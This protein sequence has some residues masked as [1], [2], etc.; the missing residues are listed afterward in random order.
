MINQNRFLT[1]DS[2]MNI[3]DKTTSGFIAA[4]HHG[5]ILFFN[6]GAENILEIPIESAPQNNLLQYVLPDFETEYHNFYRAIFS[7]SHSAYSIITFQSSSGKMAPVIIEGMKIENDLCYLWM[8][9]VKGHSA[10]TNSRLAQLLFYKSV[11][12]NLNEGVALFD[13]NGMFIY[14]NDACEA[15]F[16]LT[17]EEIKKRRIHDLLDPRQAQLFEMKK[18]QLVNGEQSRFGI[19]LNSSTER[20]SFLKMTISP[21]YNTAKESTEILAIFSDITESR[22][23]EKKIESRLELERLLAHISYYF[24]HVSQKN[25]DQL[26]DSTLLKIGLYAKIDRSYLFQFTDDLFYCSNTHEWCNEK[27]EPQITNLQNIP[28]TFLPWW[29]KKLNSFEIIHIPSVKD[30]P[31]E[32]ASEKEIL[33]AQDIKSLIVLPVRGN[34]TLLGFIGFDSVKSY[35]VWEDSDIQALST[36]AVVFGNAITRIKYESELSQINKRLNQKVVERTRE[37]EKIYEFSQNVI[38]KINLVVIVTDEK[39]FIKTLNPYARKL[40][41]N[42]PDLPF[43]RLHLFDIL[44]YK[45]QNFTSEEAN[46]LKIPREEFNSFIESL[47]KGHGDL[48]E[49][50]FILV[51]RE[52]DVINV[53]LT[54]T[55]LENRK[56]KTD[57]FFAA[58]NITER[59][60]AEEMVK[61]RENENRAIVEAVPDMLF[62][63]GR[64]GQFLDYRNNRS[65]DPIIQSGSI[66]G[67]RIEELLPKEVADLT[68]SSLEQAFETQSLTHFDFSMTIDNKVRYFENRITTVSEEVAFSFVRDISHKKETEIAVRDTM[69]KLSVLIQSLKDGVLFEGKDKCISLINP[70]FIQLFNLE[71]YPEELIGNDFGRI[72]QK[73]KNLVIDCNSFINRM[74]E[75]IQMREPV[76]N[77]EIYFLDGRVFE[78]DFTP[79]IV[80]S[81]FIGQLWQYRDITER[82]LIEKNAIIER[83]LGFSLA[84][85]TTIEK[86]LEMAV[87]NIILIDCVD[88]VGIYFIN[89]QKGELEL[90]VS[91]GGSGEFMEKVGKIKRNDVPYRLFRKSRPQ[92]GHYSEMIGDIEAYLKAGVEY[93]GVIPIIHEKETIGS[94]NIGHKAKFP[95]KDTTKRSLEIIATL[96]GGAIERI[97]IENKLRRSQLNFNLLFNTLD[98]FVFILDL[99]GCIIN[100]NPIIEKRLGY[101]REELSGKSIFDLHPPLYHGPAKSIFQNKIEGIADIYS[102]PLLT[103]DQLEIPVET[104]LLVGKWDNNNV[105][106]AI[107]RDITERVKAERLIKSESR[108]QFALEGAGDGLWDMNLETTELFLSASWKT[109][110]GYSNEEIPNNYYEWASRVHPD[111]LELSMEELVDEIFGT[112]STYNHEHRIQCKDGNYKWILDRA[113]IVEWNALGRPQR[114]IG[115][116][117]DITQRKQFEEQLQKTVEREKEL[118]DLKSRFVS[119]ASHEF[120]TPLASILMLSEIVIKY[121]DRIKPAEVFEKLKLIKDHVMQLSD[122][123]NNVLQ[124]SKIKDGKIIYN[125]E[126]I[127]LNALC[128]NIM[129]GFYSVLESRNTI[130][131]HSDFNRLICLIDKQMI[132][133]AIT[134]LISNALKYTPNNP[135]IKVNLTLQNN[136]I[137]LTV[138]DNGIG[139]PEEDQKHMFTPFFRAGNTKTIQGNGLGLSIIRESIQMHHG[140]VSF[141]S[142]MNKGSR[143][144]IHLPNIL[145]IS[146]D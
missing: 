2:I 108:W 25:L 69:Q 59:R 30:L 97:S 80:Q 123:V 32:A 103:K 116:H 78:R 1:P 45:H 74:E 96:L 57:L 111:H 113:K 141:E 126:E 55:K 9:S 136:E 87:D 67:T 58:K 50:E 22:N 42:N 65:I 34:N 114:V 29:M 54:A 40:I 122:I 51:S 36:I 93:Y 134:N 7:E 72:I 98:D 35:K 24:I 68:L 100:T 70:S 23:Y 117:T 62:K 14:S 17:K 139:I 142:Q 10:H 101:T 52:G 49:D 4:N 86:A 60:R 146:S 48:F 124:L 128:L 99:E 119:T 33:E 28:V 143:F 144:T 88:I 118:S 47:T 18:N 38:K 91:R 120:R 41:G 39:G 77:E 26:I 13:A 15:L 44:I 46:F 90:R 105:L 11:I 19:T 102:F 109:M 129:E 64:D 133:Q 138:A 83:N 92:Y 75:I 110:L 137:V 56:G 73:S 71:D 16:E 145:L 53:L 12:E 85:T 125:P 3:I 104:K 5:D 127:D 6:K 20:E 135:E 94:I 79:V 131:F 63:I 76:L 132:Q 112:A 140:T 21:I 27:I 8:T 130:Q 37:I 43:G 81:E 66:V 95:I 89:E 115:I 84:E 82:K 106:Y 107:S 31:E 121:F 61:I